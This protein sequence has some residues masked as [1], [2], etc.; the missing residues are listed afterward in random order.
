MAIRSI[1]L[2]APAETADPNRGPVAAA[3]DLAKQDGA[4]LTVFCVALD[5]TTPGRHVDAAPVAATINAAA[6]AAGVSVHMITE[7]SH[8]IGLPQVVAEYARLHD[9]S[10]TGS[11]NEGLLSEQMLAE[12]LLFDSGR[13]L[14][15]VPSAWG[16]PI[17][18]NRVAIAWDNSAAAARALG[19]AIALFDVRDTLLLAIEGDKPFGMGIEQAEVIT[20]SMRRGLV[21]ELANSELAGRSIATALQQEAGSNN[22]G[23]LVMGGFGHT[24]L[25]RFVLGSATAGVLAN[26]I[27]PILLSH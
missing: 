3:I 16:G 20:T 17:S 1:F 23:L 10:I 18:T 21:A 13:P 4:Q 7:H 14:L 6:S 15:L 22:A 2:M 12:N 19:D 11:S 26:P 24:R 27:M 9:L 8:A 25:R 5:V